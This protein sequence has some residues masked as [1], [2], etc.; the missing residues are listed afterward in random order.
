[1][2]KIFRVIWSH[3]QQAWVVV[4]ELVKSHTKT[5]AYTDKRAQVCTSDYFLDKQ[6]DKFKLSLLSLV[7]LGI[8][9]SPSAAANTTNTA[10]AYLQDGATT[11]N[12]GYDAGTIGIGKESKASY[13]AIAIG[14]KS[15]A[16]ARHNIAI[17]YDTQAGDHKDHVNSVAVG[18]NIK[19]DGKEA[20]A[21]GSAS[22][23]GKGSVV[24]GR[25]ASAENIEQAVVIGHSATASK[26]KSIV[27]GAN[28]KADG[29]GSI[30][31][32][33]DD[34][35]T[36]RYQPD[37][38]VQGQV[39]G[40]SQDES[41]KTTASGGAS[42][43]IGGGSLAKGE[44]SI[45]L[46]PLASASKDEGIA[47]GANSKSTDEYGIA[48]GG[49]ATA[50][51]KYAV[52]LGWGSK[53]V[54]IDSIAIGKSATTAGASSVVVG[55]NID[56]TGQNLVA[57]GSLASAESHATALGYMAS[58]GGMSSVAVGERAKTNGS[59]DRATALGNN[60]V[61]T[62]G[63]GVALGYGSNA[64]TAGGVVGLKQN[65]SVTT[66]ASTDANGFKSTEKVDG[67]KI[68]AVSVG[69]GS[70]NKL[71]KRQIVNVAAGTQD[72]DA[73]NVAQLKSLTMLIGGDNS[74]SGKVGIWS[75]KLEVKG[76]NNEITTKAEGSTITIS[77]DDTIKNQLAQ[78]ADKMSSFKIKIDNN[79]TTIT[80]G[81][82]I[83][84]TAGDNI[85]L[86]HT[87]GNIKISTIGKLI[88]KTEMVN[89]GLKI[90]Y[91]DNTHDIIA[92]GKDGKD[93]AKGEPGIPGPAG[94]IG[95]RGEPGPKGDMGPAG[96]RG[97]AGPT[98][99]QGPAGPRGEQGLKGEQGPAGP[100]G[101]AG[102]TG[103][104]GPVGPKG[105][106]GDQGPVGPAGPAG[107][108]GIQGPKGD[109]GPKGDTGLRGETGPAG[110]A[111]P[112]GPVG[113]TGPQG[114][115]G[116]QGQKGERGE[117]G[118]AGPAGAKGDRGEP[119]QAGPEG[120]R[121]PQGTA[122]AQGPKGD[123]GDPGQAGPA[124]PKGDKGDTGPVGP[125]GPTG[126][127]GPQGPTG[128]AGANGM[129]ITPD[130]TTTTKTEGDGADKK[131]TT[132][133]AGA[134]GT[135]IVQK[136]SNNQPLKSADYKLDGTTVKAKDA[137]GNNLT[138]TVKADGV[139]ATD[140]DSKNTVNA[141]GMTVGPKDDTQ[142]DKSAATYN[143]D[144]VTVKGNDGADAIALTSKEGQDGKTTN[145]LA[146][147]GENGKDAVS[148]TSG[149]DGTAPEISFAKNGEGTDAKGT[150]SITGLKDVERNPD[151]TAKDRT[152]AANTGYV[153]DRLK[154]MNDRKPFEYFEKDSVTGEVKTETVNGKQVPVTL[155]RG[156]DGKFYKESDLKGK[157]FDPATNTYK[158][159]D[160]RPATLTEVASNNVTV[161]AMPSDASN[162]P[163]AMS[164]VGSGLGL[165]DDAESNKTALTPTDAQKAIAGDNKDGKGGLLAQ[166][167][168]ALNNV[169][170]VKDLQAIAQAGLDLTGNNADTTV[171]RPL[172]TKLTVEG[173]GKWNG[174][175]SAANN[176]YVEAQVADNKL[177]VKMNRDLTNLN[178]VT[179]GT[180]T[181]TG[182]KNTINLT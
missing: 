47:I 2:N 55:A 112:R 86:E 159:A 172:G 8:F 71:I 62:V 67:N 40:Q 22:K 5:S 167:G 152:A 104:I 129:K 31:I 134:D 54:G 119:G 85:K 170:T 131:V 91:T 28:A 154:E 121:G 27:I 166:T 7:L 59:A 82:T 4:S 24:L 142:A 72:T 68:G 157:V 132:A 103:P 74:S 128:P 108:Q 6:Q 139:T 155:V 120:P 146:L 143:R 79:E 42:I 148:I 58:A 75:G 46:G 96:P 165:K 69:V 18:N 161:Q 156:K 9:F 168:N 1:M 61:V 39:Q 180:A 162:T 73:V 114:I 21:I 150:G 99:A 127:A 25:Q 12:N 178:S 83:Q 100:K 87:N 26:A 17:G 130:A 171:H 80:N 48:V 63:G 92:K 163:I 95:P 125:Q 33:G 77:L 153:D 10:Q 140:K 123:K 34:L 149:A 29:Y 173:E 109:A 117:T 60:T 23:A 20:V 11:S 94:P 45:V 124:G 43:A 44:G 13:G 88:T 177:V 37:V 176:L 135:S 78:I 179:L 16:E 111:G 136:D 32:G 53:G 101:E 160:G 64:S 30:S 36:T 158:N 52:A 98:G 138:T 19:I 107:A 97:P 70:G 133:T 169:A 41:K 145:T 102:P 151:G 51:G 89:G 35:K 84:F 15:K 174:K 38:T 76:T 182:D 137:E 164:N 65:H 50:T 57:V 3:A 122:G 116:I 81:N 66:G 56:V 147:K 113:P 181:M 144:G 141:D 93:G 49:S 14:Q 118:P 106:K 175:D 115:P 90:T 126:P 105:E 110:P